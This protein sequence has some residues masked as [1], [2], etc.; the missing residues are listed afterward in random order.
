[1]TL[2]QDSEHPTGVSDDTPRGNSD[3]A[4]ARLRKAHAAI[5]M[6]KEFSTWDE[7]AETLGYPTAR[8]A[9]VACELALENEL[10]TREGKEFMRQMASDRFEAM[11]RTLWK[12]ANDKNDP[13]RWMAMDRVRALMK[14]HIDL[15]GYAAPKQQVITTPTTRQIEEFVATVLKVEKPDLE[16]ANIF[17]IEYTEDVPADSL[18]PP[19]QI[20]SV[21]VDVVDPEHPDAPSS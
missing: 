8:A 5:Q 3:V 9:R 16:E 17:D 15:H 18:A 2:Q 4:R 11:L 7:I 19:R 1:M 21:Q 12:E 13:N 10:Q 20:E 14:D 6:K